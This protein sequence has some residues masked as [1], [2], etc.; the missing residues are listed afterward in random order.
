MRVAAF[1]SDLHTGSAV[2]PWPRS[3]EAT[4][5]DELPRLG[6]GPRFTIARYL[7]DCWYHM[8]EEYIPSIVESVG[9]K[10]DLLAVVGDCIDG[11]QRKSQS[12][13]LVTADMGD[14]A[15]ASSALLQ[16]LAKQFKRIIRV[17]GTAY[18]DGFEDELGRLDR[19]CGVARV[20]QMFD[21]HLSDTCKINLA[22]HPMGGG[23]MYK[24]TVLDRELLWVK[25]RAAE[26]KLDMPDVLVRSHLHEY[27][28]LEQEDMQ[29]FITPC[30]QMPNAWAVKTGWAKWQPT[31]G[32]L[33]AFED[34]DTPEPLRHATGWRF[35]H[36]TYPIPRVPVQTVRLQDL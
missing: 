20:R 2:A 31:L 25:R 6:K 14:Q 7:T 3:D 5:A 24:G 35:H 1:V 16:P 27:A 12:T 8:V 34:I 33:M 18:H 23:A 21:L 11:K 17:H 30:W 10:L 26:G 22:H 28:Q 32:I 29:M 15:R 13:G 9:G 19:D 4:G 36:H